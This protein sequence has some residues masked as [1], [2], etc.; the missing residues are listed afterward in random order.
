MVVRGLFVFLLS[1][2]AAL[3]AENAQN[4]P[5]A[6][7]AKKDAV[8][9][10]RI[11]ALIDDLGHDSFERRELAEKRLTEVGE[12]ALRLLEDAAK[13]SSDSE[14]RER[15]A[16]LVAS[17]QGR[18]FPFVWSVPAHPMRATRIALTPDGKG[19]VCTG[20]DSV[21]LGDVETGK[22]LLNF[23]EAPRARFY[24]C[25]A[26]TVRIWD[27][28]TGKELKQFACGSLMECAYFVDR[29]RRIICTGK[30]TDLTLQ[31]WDVDKGRRIM[32][33]PT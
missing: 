8:D 32:S 1:A 24:R 12:P 19:Y 21:C 30:E 18:L 29:D 15:A 16:K 33:S 2:T 26:I 22:V 10:K 7:D 5:A 13:Q 9:E 25:L 3:C 6:K 11:R 31:L 27:I 20:F 17:I 14:V 4:P 28:A 23:G